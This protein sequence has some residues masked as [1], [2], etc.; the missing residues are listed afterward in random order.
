MSYRAPEPR[1]KRPAIEVVERG[2]RVWHLLLAMVIAACFGRLLS[3]RVSVDCDR[4][5]GEC[6]YED[7][8][9]TARR[10]TVRMDT[11]DGAALVGSPSR[12]ALM[13][14]GHEVRITDTSEVWDGADKARMA[15]D[16]TFYFNGGGG[17]FFH[18]SYGSNVRIPLIVAAIGSLVP[19]L[20]LSLWTRR[21]TVRPDE[22]RLDATRAPLG[23][24]AM[25]WFSLE[26]TNV[27]HAQSVTSSSPKVWDA[28]VVLVTE[29]DGEV[30]V[31]KRMATARAESLARRIN[32]AL[33]RAR[34]A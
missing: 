21:L 2:V 17:R 25:R 12:V 15:Y 33:S 28:R 5:V 1:P 16:L 6:V 4:D 8:G 32:E 29:R 3:H 19:L 10:G 9:L 23:H 13:S 11:L 34:A 7:D 20:F 24:L 26:L 30:L 27:R 22:G 14:K 18:G 31:Q